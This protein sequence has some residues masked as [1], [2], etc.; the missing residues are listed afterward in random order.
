M[1]LR[2]CSWKGILF[3]GK[4]DKCTIKDVLL[5]I[6]IIISVYCMILYSTSDSVNASLDNQ[7]ERYYASSKKFII[8]YDKI[9]FISYIWVIHIIAVI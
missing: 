9:Y 8:Y 2:V 3:C 7:P 6:S 5:I 1:V 4:A